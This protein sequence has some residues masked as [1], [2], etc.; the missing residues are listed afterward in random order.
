MK[1]LVTG[2]ARSGKSR[3]AIQCA[4]GLARERIYLATAE[5]LD[6]EMAERI[7]AHRRARGPGWKT[8]E[9]PLEI[10]ARLSQPLPVVVDC[11]T[12]WVSNLLMRHG[13]DAEFD[14]VFV[15][16]V[17]AFRAAENPVIVVTNEVGQGIVPDNRLARRFRDVAGQLAQRVAAAADR[18]VLLV[19][20]IPLSIKS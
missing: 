2:G 4:E 14:A 9:E 5:A 15:E 13:I 18:V 17:A 12:L 10:A 1:M 20:G 8:I 19:A 11:L 16:F 6:S 3:Y 7:A